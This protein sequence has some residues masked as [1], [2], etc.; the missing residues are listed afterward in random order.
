MVVQISSLSDRVDS[1]LL[2]KEVDQIHTVS[3]RPRFYILH[4]PWVEKASLTCYR[5]QYD[6]VLYCDKLGT[7]HDDLRKLS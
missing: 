6:T 1:L 3:P 5:W 7:L 4:S 2:G